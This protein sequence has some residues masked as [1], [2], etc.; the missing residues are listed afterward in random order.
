M[1]AHQ[2]RRCDMLRAAAV[3][4]RADAALARRGPRLELPIKGAERLGLAQ[5]GV[6]PP[7]PLLS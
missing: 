4:R 3:G 7:Q 2:R 1:G 6:V 5:G